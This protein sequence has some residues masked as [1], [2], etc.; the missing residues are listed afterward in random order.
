LEDLQ[1]LVL[2]MYKGGILYSEAFREFQKI[3]VLTALREQKWNQT[4]AAQ[5]LGVRLNTFRRLIH[6]FQLDIPSL[7][8]ARRRPPQRARHLPLEKK[9]RAT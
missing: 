2:R 1:S 9:H 5:T 3:F 7:R 8:A 4:R 6:K